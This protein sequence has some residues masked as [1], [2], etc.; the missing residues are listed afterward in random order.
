MNKTLCWTLE[1]VNDGCLMVCS[2]P[3]KIILTLCHGIV[4]VF[5]ATLVF[6]PPKQTQFEGVSEFQSTLTEL[7]THQRLQFSPF[8]LASSLRNVTLVYGRW[9]MVNITEQKHT[10]RS[11]SRVAAALWLINRSEFTE[12]SSCPPYFPSYIY[13]SIQLFVM[14]FIAQNLTVSCVSKEQTSS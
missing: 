9:A 5:C 3:A 6:I 1:I 8:L 7:S 13:P 11:P 12:P 4:C 14:M 10:S 2:L